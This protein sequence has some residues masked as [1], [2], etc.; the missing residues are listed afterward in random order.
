VRDVGRNINISQISIMR[1]QEVAII[2]QRRLLYFLEKEMAVSI[3]SFCLHSVTVFIYMREGCI[4]HESRQFRLNFLEI[5]FERNI[6]CC[7]YFLNCF[8][9]NCEHLS[10]L[11]LCTEFHTVTS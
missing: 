2:T 6:H 4:F 7:K 5:N 11:G 10:S 3:L 1:F 9:E 8:F